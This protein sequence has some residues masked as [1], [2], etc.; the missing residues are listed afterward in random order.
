M[1]AAV[2][3]RQM[4]DLAAA[5]ASGRRRAA[6][7]RARRP[8]RGRGG[9]DVGGER[10]QV[11]AGP[12]GERPARPRGEFVP[13]QPAVH[14]RGLQRVDYLLAVGVARPE[15]VAARRGRVLRSCRHR[16]LPRSHD[17]GKRSAAA[18]RRPSAAR[19]LARRAAY[20][21][22]RLDRSQTG[23]G[24]AGA[25]LSAGGCG[26]GR[27]GGSSGSGS[28]AR[29]APQCRLTPFSR[30]AR[31]RPPAHAT[32]Q[33]QCAIPLAATG[34]PRGLAS[35]SHSRPKRDP[36]QGAAAAPARHRHPTAPARPGAPAA[37]VSLAT[38]PQAPRRKAHQRWNAYAETTP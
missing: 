20:V 1:A 36:S 21:R 34:N 17:A 4:P 22:R 27:R 24:P 32:T 30:C 3:I 31:T 18:P 13:G 23:V 12:R 28:S 2:M 5:L 11:G 9:R 26:Q 38:P 33:N 29:S 14:E 16:H 6:G 10:G 15:P 7:G 37:L 19:V 25:H 8:G 35:R